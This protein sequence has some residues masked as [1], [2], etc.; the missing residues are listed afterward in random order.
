M[1]IKAEIHTSAYEGSIVSGSLV[2]A[3][4]TTFLGPVGALIGLGYTAASL[5]RSNK[6]ANEVMDQVITEKDEQIIFE[7]FAEQLK[8]SNKKKRKFEITSHDTANNSPLSK[9]LFGNDITKTYYYTK[10]D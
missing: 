5:I 8:H 9:L 2:T 3:A 7:H 4:L 10:D 1:G 6:D